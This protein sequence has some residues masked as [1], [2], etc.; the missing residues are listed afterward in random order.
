MVTLLVASGSPTLTAF[1]AD[2]FAHA[3]ITGAITTTQKETLRHLEQHGAPDILLLDMPLPDEG[4][5]SIVRFMRDNSPYQNT[6]IVMLLEEDLSI[7]TRPRLGIEHLY[8][9]PVSRP[10][11]DELIQNLLAMLKRKDG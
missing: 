5:R 1:Y 2:Y 3:P 10:V 6:Y 11:L 9:K 7:L 4:G 8:F